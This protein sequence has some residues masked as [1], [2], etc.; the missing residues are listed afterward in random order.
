MLTD[1]TLRDE[2]TQKRIEKNIRVMSEVDAIDHLLGIH[3]TTLNRL[4]SFVKVVRG[5]ELC[6][7]QGRA[8]ICVPAG[9][10]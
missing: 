8:L 1:T 4:D 10:K 9:G 2:K 5:E 7:C 3:E 6:I